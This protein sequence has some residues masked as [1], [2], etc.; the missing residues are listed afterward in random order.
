M[1]LLLYITELDQFS[2]ILKIP[3][4]GERGIIAAM[5]YSKEAYFDRLRPDDR[6]TQY[7]SSGPSDCGQ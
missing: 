2:N 6:R 5:P 4:R 7:L 3:F 1:F